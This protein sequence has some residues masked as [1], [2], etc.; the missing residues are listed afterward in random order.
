MTSIDKSRSQNLSP[1]LAPRWPEGLSIADVSN[2]HWKPS[3]LKEFVV[4]VHSRCNLACN[5]CY[6]YEMA[7]DSWTTQPPSMSVDV[8][9]QTAKRIA[10]HAEKHELPTCSIVLHG[11]EPLLLGEKRLFELLTIFDDELC[12]F[13]SPVFCM[14]TNGLLLTDSTLQMLDYFGVQIGISLDGDRATNDKHRI[15]RSGAGTY[16]A[17]S[18]RLKSLRDGKYSHLFSGLLA[19]IDVTSDPI[20]VYQALR[21]FDPPAVDFMLPHGNWTELPPGLDPSSE[22]TP[23]AD[24]LIK[25]F[26]FWRAS[27]RTEPYVRVFNEI[28][29]GLD[30]NDSHWEAFGLSPVTLATIQTDGAF[31]LVDTL[32]ST[33]NGAAGTGMNVF[34]DTLDALLE[35][36]SVIAQQIG[37][38]ALSATCLACEFA[39]VC[40]AGYYPHRYDQKSGFMNPSVYCRDL[41]KLIDHVRVATGNAHD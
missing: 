4:K 24:W 35:H 22:Q 9:R 17:V 40:G 14:Q 8:A 27:T 21:S 37:K 32:K 34:D 31:E 33:F 15:R 29:R 16:A 25:M 2:E 18:E 11:G 38:E 10:E 26:D 30:G 20:N 7:D 3:P 23:Y 19:T 41:K 28:M 39:T 5:Y 6:I 12:T 1:A 36:P 13:T